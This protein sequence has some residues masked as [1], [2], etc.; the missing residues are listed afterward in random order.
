MKILKI[1]VLT[2]FSATLFYSCS[3]APAGEKAETTEAAPVEEVTT[4][5]EYAVKTDASVVNWT[6]SKVGGEHVGTLNF[7]EGTITVED[8]NITAGKLVIDMASLANTDLPDDKKPKLEGH[9]KSPD[10]FDV[11]AFPTSTFELTKVTGLENDPDATHLVY[12]NL[13]LKDVTKQISFKAKVEMGE[14][15]VTVSTPD[16]TID[17]ADFNVKYGS[18]RFFDDL[19]DKAINDNVGLS[20]SVSAS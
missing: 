10:F 6:G 16:F 14:N 20:I 15:G 4:G 5:T 1:S 2:L 17:R 8:G 18:T 11:A 9:L 12:G 7:S 3:N 19:K 13:T